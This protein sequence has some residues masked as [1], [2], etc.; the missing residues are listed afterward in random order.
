MHNQNFILIPTET[1]SIETEKGPAVAEISESS[2]TETLTG[3]LSFEKDVEYPTL[4][5]KL[6]F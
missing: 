2:P 6:T 4:T 5:F 3:L 1:E